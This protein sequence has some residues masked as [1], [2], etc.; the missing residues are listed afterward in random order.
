MFIIKPK[1]IILKKRNFYRKTLVLCIILLH[2]NTYMSAQI[3]VDNNVGVNAQ[4]SDLQLAI[5]EA[6]NG[7]V[8]YVHPSNTNYGD[9]TINKSLTI[10]GKSHS[11]TGVEISRI[12]NITIL[13]S[14]SGTTLKGLRVFIIRLTGESGT[15]FASN[16]LQVE[17][18]TIERCRVNGP[19]YVGNINGTTAGIEHYNADETHQKGASTNNILIRGNVFTKT[20][21]L[22][23]TNTTFSHNFVETAETIV[24][25]PQSTIL[26][27]N[28]FTIESGTSVIRNYGASI[29]K[30]LVQNSVFLAQSATRTIAV[31]ESQFDNCLTY[32]YSSSGDLNFG[33][34]IGMLTNN[35]VL[36]TNPLFTDATG[37]NFVVASNYTLQ[38]GSPA[39][40]S[41]LNGEDIGLFGNGYTFNNIGTPANYPTITITNSTA[42]IPSGGTLSV[43]ITGKAN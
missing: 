40:G 28:I 10:I 14:G 8:I 2:I 27:H 43:T 21:H 7:D 9:I 19:F 20:I 32:N 22:D 11:E 42:A 24:F 23:G 36:N 35:I 17:N 39:L 34:A 26:N 29:A 12:N 15:S 6:S 18:I 3:I 1:T 38:A 37:R 5:D 16:A 4:Y 31:T 33:T 13:H 25:R 30:V 41:G